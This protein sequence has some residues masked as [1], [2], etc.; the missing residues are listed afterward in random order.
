MIG[1]MVSALKSV[2]KKI[3]NLGSRYETNLEIEPQDG[4][5]RNI[6]MNISLYIKDLVGG[7]TTNNILMTLIT[8]KNIEKF[9]KGY[10]FLKF[11]T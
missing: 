7:S 5:I 4:D 6:K 8:I 9:L 10:S 1:V 3:I 2:M 11:I